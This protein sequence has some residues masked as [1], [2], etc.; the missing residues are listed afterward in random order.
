MNAN[1]FPPINL[2]GGTNSFGSRMRL[3]GK[4]LP[5][6]F[7]DVQFFQIPF[8]GIG[9]WFGIGISPRWEASRGGWRD[10]WEWTERNRL[11]GNIEQV[12]VEDRVCSRE[13]T[14]R[15]MWSVE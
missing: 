4:E 1:L 12:C 5:A 3:Q 2:E 8:I 7:C 11:C 15:S 14:S 13:R 6:M 9:E 10:I